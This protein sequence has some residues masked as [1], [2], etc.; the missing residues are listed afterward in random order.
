MPAAYLPA[1]QLVQTVEAVASAYFPASQSLQAEDPAVGWIVPAGHDVQTAVAEEVD[2]TGPY[3][4]TAHKAPVQLETVVSPTSAENFPA[5][6]STQIE[7]PA[8][9]AYL[10]APHLVQALDPAV[11]WYLP[12]GHDVQTA[13]AEEVDPT[14]PYLP[15]AQEEPVQ[16]ETVAAPT[17]AEYLPASQSMQTEDPAVGWYLPAPQLIQVLATVAPTVVEYV[18][19][20]QLM[21]V[22]ATVAPTVVEYVPAVQLVQTVEAVPAAYLPAGHDVQAAAA[23]EL[24]PTAPYLPA[25]Q[26]EPV[27]VEAPTAAEYLPASQSMQKSEPAL[28]SL[29]VPRTRDFPSAYLP[30][31]QE[32]QEQYAPPFLPLQLKY[33]PTGQAAG[34]GQ[35]HAS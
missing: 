4:P 13:V 15:A 31:S 32:R 35:F 3:L 16:V 6:Q 22:L 9:D 27:Q 1:S 11:G 21:Q 5:S 17:S 20:P 29:S 19:A 14:G 34:S 8:L 25:A 33:C 10:P 7:E 23:E 12:A 28:Y 2:P 26:K 18:P 30:V 24:D